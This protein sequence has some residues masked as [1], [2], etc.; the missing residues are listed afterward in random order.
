MSELDDIQRIKQKLDTYQAETPGFDELFGAEV[1]DETRL[2]NVCQSTLGNYVAAAPSYEELLQPRKPV[3]PHRPKHVSP[4]WTFAAAAAACLAFLFLLQGPTEMNQDTMS[5][6]NEGS[7]VKPIRKF[8][9]HETRSGETFLTQKLTTPRTIKRITIPVTSETVTDNTPA[10]NAVHVDSVYRETFEK[11]SSKD[12]ATLDVDNMISIEEAYARARAA[13]QHKKHDKLLA[14]IHMNSINR[15]LSFVN[16]NRGSNPLQAASDQYTAGQNSLEGFPSSM[17]RAATPSKNEWTAPANISTSS[18]S[19]YEANYSIPINVGLSLSIPLTN[20]LEL[21]TGLTYTY[22]SSNTSGITGTSTFD[23]HREL[24]YMGIPFNLAI[25]LIES[26]GFRFYS[27][28]GAAL[29]KGLVGKQQS[30]VVTTTGDVDIWK[31]SQKVYGIQPLINCQ[32]GLSYD[33]S[34]TFLLYLE[35]GATYSLPADQPISRRTEEPFNFNIGFGLRYR[36][37]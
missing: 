1:T 9:K 4:L 34:K 26:N 25:N 29:E 22:L 15:L 2:R 6:L 31:E 36:L 12:L 33:L 27:G 35:P 30:R 17:L 8:G 14:G 10:E 11:I 24:H 21:Q 20:M 32:L 23:L 18:L 19:N 37:N 28:I 16:T 5:L 7:T 13:K 3:V